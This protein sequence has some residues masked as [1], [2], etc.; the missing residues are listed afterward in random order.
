MLNPILSRLRYFYIY[1]MVWALIAGVHTCI[2]WQFYGIPLS[3]ALIDGLVFNLLLAALGLTLWYPVRYVNF[4]TQNALTVFLNH[5]AICFLFLCLWIGGAYLFLQMLCESNTRYLDFL[6]SSFPWRFFTGLLFYSIIILNYY[7]FIYYVS[8]K[9]KLI[10][11][12]EMQTLIRDTQLSLLKSQLN[13]HFIFNSLN[14]VSALTLSDPAR[15]QDMVIRLSAFLRYALGQSAHEMISLSEELENCMLYLDIE[16]TR[17]GDKLLV[18]TTIQQGT[19]QQKIP[20]MILQPLLENAIKYGVY[21]SLEPVTIHI[22]VTQEENFLTIQISNVFEQ[23]AELKTGKGL[24]LKN[25]SERMQLI[26][27][28]RDLFRIDK[29]DGIFQ[30]TL[31]FPQTA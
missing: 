20:G 25:V 2:L 3:F 6:H 24:G 15:A 1:L 29:K 19:E 12:S 31:H 10:R 27:G 17:F 14:S 30:V 13:P 5:V 28:N 4:D 23:E 9:K 26:Y 7:L 21:E 18:E 8:F 22:A 16:K 11:E